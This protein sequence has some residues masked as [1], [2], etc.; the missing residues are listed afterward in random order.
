MA[1]KPAHVVNKR[2]AQLA[3]LLTEGYTYE[4]CAKLAGILP[5]SVKAQMKTKY[6][7]IYNSLKSKVGRPPKVS[8]P[9]EEAERLRRS[10]EAAETY[11]Q[12]QEQIQARRREICDY[13]FED[14]FRTLEEVGAKFGLTRERVRQIAQDDFPG[15]YEV[16]KTKR[17]E[18]RQKAKDDAKAAL[19]ERFCKTCGVKINSTNQARAYCCN[20]HR[21]IR[22]ALRYHLEP[23]LRA[24]H[25]TL[26][27]KWLLNAAEEG[28]PDISE[29]QIGYAQRVLDPELSTQDRG[30]WLTFGSKNRVYALEAYEKNW[31]IFADLP[32]QIQEQV[33]RIHEG[34]VEA[35]A[36]SE[37]RAQAD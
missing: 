13:L 24:H 5:S 19:P 33:K 25:K 37:L 34:R 27:A 30:R 32:E 6:P 31:P 22:L 3:K 17:R 26:V 10:Q 9:E 12:R 18:L 20:E 36:E 2:D 29:T 15:L 35:E 4:Q 21:E 1:R 28:R 11:H 14:P 23:E 16:R 8:S 7:D